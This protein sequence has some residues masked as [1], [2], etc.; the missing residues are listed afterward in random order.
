MGKVAR[1]RLAQRDGELG[2]GGEPICGFLREADREVVDPGLHRRVR[3][4]LATLVGR[5]RRRQRELAEVWPEA[6]DNLAEIVEAFDG[7]MV[8]LTLGVT[9]VVLFLSGDDTSSASKAYM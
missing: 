4:R 1:S 9:S 8:A 6:V 5:A 3:T 2:G 7:L